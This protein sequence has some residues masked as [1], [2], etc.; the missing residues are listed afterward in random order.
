M[1]QQ[2]DDEGRREMAGALIA[3]MLG[4][5]SFAT[6]Q[7]E[8]YAGGLYIRRTTLPSGAERFIIFRRCN[9]E[10]WDSFTFEGEEEDSL[11]PQH[12][13]VA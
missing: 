3:V 8:L 12:E 10:V 4:A 6:I 9:G 11:D 2:E 13:S 7:A 1:K 5:I